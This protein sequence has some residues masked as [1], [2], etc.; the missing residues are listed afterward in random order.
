MVSNLDTYFHV[1]WYLNI[2]D[3]TGHLKECCQIKIVIDCLLCISVLFGILLLLIN[4]MGRIH[5]EAKSYIMFT[6][7]YMVNHNVFKIGHNKDVI[8]SKHIW[9]LC[10]S[11]VLFFYVALV[12]VPSRNVME[13]RNIFKIRSCFS[14]KKMNYRSYIN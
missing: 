1:W 11:S 3:D 4:K 7:K 5:H 8:K 6:C 14:Y 9:I 13:C 12:H 2:D 10:L